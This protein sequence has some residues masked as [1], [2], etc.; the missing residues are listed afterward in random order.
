MDSEVQYTA[1]NGAGL[2]VVSRD[3]PLVSLST[4][5]TA[6]SPFPVPLAPIEQGQVSGFAF[7]LYN[8]MWD[9]NYILWYPYLKEDKDFRARFDILFSKQ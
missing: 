2:R 9:T 7:N 1:A 6:P 8:N 5:Q 4:I 3:V